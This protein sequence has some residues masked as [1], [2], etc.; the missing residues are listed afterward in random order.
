LYISSLT[1]FKYVWEVLWNKD[2]QANLEIESAVKELEDWRMNDSSA[3]VFHKLTRESLD[4]VIRLTEYQDAKAT[5]LLTVNSFIGAI[6]GVFFVYF[7]DL[8]PIEVVRYCFRVSPHQ[9]LF[10]FTLFISY[11]L[12]FLYAIYFSAG[13]MV[14]FFAIRTR[15]VMPSTWANSG[16]PNPPKS[17]LFYSFICSVTPKAWASSFRYNEFE[18]KKPDL[19]VVDYVKNHIIETYLVAHKVKDK[20]RLLEPGQ[21]LLFNSIRIMLIWFVFQ[22]III[23]FSL[24]GA[25]RIGKTTSDFKIPEFGILCSTINITAGSPKTTLADYGTFLGA[26]HGTIS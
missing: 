12:F 20:I 15:F 2:S 26:E 1:D 11:I 8:Y 6:V 24:L 4:E 25:V 16:D 7:R 19:L 18:E 13:A 9:L 3:E 14:I 23:S 10:G 21:R 5:R 17:R 22:L